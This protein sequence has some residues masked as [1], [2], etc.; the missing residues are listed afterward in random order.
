MEDMKEMNWKKKEVVEK[1]AV[2]G[3]FVLYVQI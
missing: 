2:F 3:W 1:D